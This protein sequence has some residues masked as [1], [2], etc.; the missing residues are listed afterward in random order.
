MLGRHLEPLVLAAVAILGLALLPA[1]A[2]AGT[3]G[4]TDANV[5]VQVE[6]GYHQEDPA[7]GDPPQVTRVAVG[8]DCHAHVETGEPTNA[9]TCQRDQHT[10]VEPPIPFRRGCGA[11]GCTIYIPPP[12]PRGSLDVVLETH[13]GEVSCEIAD[14]PCT[15]DDQDQ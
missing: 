9:T 13:A 12:N 2:A 10:E 11:N 8:V 14:P 15:V 5:T 4:P 6:A 3:G 7:P 1:Q